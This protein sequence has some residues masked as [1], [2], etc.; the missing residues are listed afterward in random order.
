MQNE[1]YGTLE[2]S[3]IRRGEGSGGLLGI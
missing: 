2:V 1:R 3:D